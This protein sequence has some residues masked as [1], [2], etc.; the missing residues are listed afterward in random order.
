M[1]HHPPASG[2]AS[3]RRRL[4]DAAAFRAVLR[5]VGADLVLCGHQHRFQFAQLDGPEGP[6][7][8][9]GGPS[10]SLR[11]EAGDRYGGYLLHRISKDETGW[12]IEVEGRRYDALL[13]RARHDFSRRVR[14]VR[15][16]GGLI[17][18]D[19]GASAP[20]SV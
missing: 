15:P 6:I 14:H 3:Y 20:A 7:P 16:G 4:T 2:M 19:A 11:A 5:D 10:A 18:E 13:R 1:L 8:V 17:L 9:L 12:L